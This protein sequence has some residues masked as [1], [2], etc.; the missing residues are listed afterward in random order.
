MNSPN[1]S[2]K[3]KFLV[4]KIVTKNLNFTWMVCSM[5]SSNLYEKFQTV[6][7][8][9]QYLILHLKSTFKLLV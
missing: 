4:V 5:F 8:Q 9:S 7:V 6:D 3:I 1:Y 2:N